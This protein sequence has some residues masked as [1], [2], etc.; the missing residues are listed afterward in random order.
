MWFILWYVS[1][2]HGTIH[3]P[4]TK[5]V[6]VLVM[7]RRKTNIFRVGISLMPC[8]EGVLVSEKLKEIRISLKQQASEHLSIELHV[9][10]TKTSHLRGQKQACTKAY[11]MSITASLSGRFFFHPTWITDR[12]LCQLEG[13]PCHPASPMPG[14]SHKHSWPTMVARSVVSA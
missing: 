10:C 6:C 13:S 4:A 3:A 5:A 12:A 7:R 14:S 11:L 2:S 1:D 8:M 9:Y